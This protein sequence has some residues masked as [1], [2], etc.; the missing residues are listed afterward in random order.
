METNSPKEVQDLSYDTAMTEA[1][2]L[3]RQLESEKMPIDEVLKKSRQVTALIKHCR[4]KIKEV[5]MEVDE[6][7]E[8]LKNVA[9]NEDGI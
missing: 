5:G 4:E 1:E 2:A 9:A 3:L 7:L 8:E 6:I